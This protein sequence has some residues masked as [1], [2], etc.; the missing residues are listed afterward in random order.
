[1]KAYGKKTPVGFEDDRCFSPKSSSNNKIKKSGD[2]KNSISSLNV[3][4]K[5]RRIFKKKQRIENKDIIVEELKLDEDIPYEEY[6]Y[7]DSYYYKQYKIDLEEAEILDDYT[8]MN[9]YW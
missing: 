8:K 7:L 3:K 9:K 1:M 6:W 5:I 4:N 2:F